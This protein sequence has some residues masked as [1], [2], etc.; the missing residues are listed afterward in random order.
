MIEEVIKK[1]LSMKKEKP[2]DYKYSSFY[3]NAIAGEV[4]EFCNLVRK[5]NSKIETIQDY[6]KYFNKSEKDYIK[7]IGF[8]LAD[9]F[10]YLI[11]NCELWN[12]DLEKSTLEKIKIIEKKKNYRS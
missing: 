3:G 1:I 9:I 11:L 10:I 7:E 6:W 12:I 5:F 8:E 2:L 4:G